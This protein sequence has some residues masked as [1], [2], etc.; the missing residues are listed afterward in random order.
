MLCSQNVP[1][2]ALHSAVFSS[3]MCTRTSEVYANLNKHPLIF[4]K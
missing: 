3:F 4:Y 1:V 2:T